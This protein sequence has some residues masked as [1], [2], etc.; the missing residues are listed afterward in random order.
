MCCPGPAVGQRGLRPAV[1]GPT[2]KARAAQSRTGR[3]LLLVKDSNPDFRVQGPACYRL[4]QRGLSAVT[5]S[6]LQP[7]CA[8][9]SPVPGASRYSSG[10]SGTCTL[11]HRRCF[12]SRRHTASLPA[13]VR[14]SPREVPWR[15]TSS[16]ADTGTAPR[17]KN[18]GGVIV[19]G[20]LL[21]CL[22]RAPCAPAQ[23][24]LRCLPDGEPSVPC[25]G[26]SGTPAVDDAVSGA[27]R[28]PARWCVVVH[29]ASPWFG[30][31]CPSLWLWGVDARMFGLGPT[32]L[33]P[34]CNPE[35]R[36]GSTGATS[37][38]RG[39]GMPRQSPAIATTSPYTSV[40]GRPLCWCARCL[41]LRPG[42]TQVKHAN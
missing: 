20:T 21:F 14:G 30:A 22:H 33:Q 27:L 34:R 31:A 38:G 4:H 42:Q 37:A 35:E 17:S 40:M 41:V 6:A 10:E 23:V 39:S 11:W 24:P 9:S 12:Y 8:A 7:L 18:R 1:P 26:V 16:P 19:D 2:C 3:L 36:A 5:G 32:S 13:N 28:V 25:D 29:A 15:L